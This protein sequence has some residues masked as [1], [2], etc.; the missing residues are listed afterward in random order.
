MSDITFTC[1]HCGQHISIDETGRGC[2]V[3]CP[4]CQAEIK[5]PQAPPPIPVKPSVSNI[6]QQ[7]HLPDLPSGSSPPHQEAPSHL[8]GIAIGIIWACISIATMI[9][10]YAWGVRFW[11]SYLLLGVNLFSACG[12][13]ASAR[14]SRR[15]ARHAF[16]VVAEGKD[17]AESLLVLVDRVKWPKGDVQQSVARSIVLRRSQSEIVDSIRHSPNTPTALAIRLYREAL[18]IIHYL[19]AHLEAVSPRLT[20]DPTNKPFVFRSVKVKK[21]R[22]T[23]SIWTR[24]ITTLF[25]DFQVCAVKER[26]IETIEDLN[27]ILNDDPQ[28]T[29]FMVCCLK[30]KWKSSNMPSD[31]RIPEMEVW[32]MQLNRESLTEGVEES[33]ELS[34]PIPSDFTISFKQQATN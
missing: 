20:V 26:L 5:V 23:G 17:F 33:S 15:T 10:M 25:F 6:R 3:K 9:G 29:T 8:G 30:W 7:A 21:Q 11:L 28:A 14:S 4:T 24:D 22:S 34:S 18:V 12:L 19:A 2:D 13:V 32:Q 16:T 31:D 1:S 27:Q